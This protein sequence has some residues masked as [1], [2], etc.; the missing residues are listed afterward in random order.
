MFLYPRQYGC[1]GLEWYLLLIGETDLCPLV[2]KNHKF[3]ESLSSRKAFFLFKV[4]CVTIAFYIRCDLMRIISIFFVNSFSTLSWFALLL[5]KHVSI[6][7]GDAMGQEFCFELYFHL[8]AGFCVMSFFVTLLRD[9][10]PYCRQ[11]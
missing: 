2:L 1:R 6:G 8:I 7:C 11:S 9:G 5:S 3:G 10:G 4:A